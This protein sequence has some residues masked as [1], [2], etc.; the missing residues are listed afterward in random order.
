MLDSKAC[1]AE[2]EGISNKQPK[3]HHVVQRTLSEYEEEHPITENL[4][5]KFRNKLWHMGQRLC[6][7]SSIKRKTIIE[8]WKSGV[9]SVWEFTLSKLTAC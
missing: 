6:A 5:S 9:N 1:N 3:L 7:V 4:C 8:S 2:T